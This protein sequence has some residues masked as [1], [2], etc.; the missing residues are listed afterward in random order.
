MIHQLKN[1]ITFV[2]PKSA[3]VP[4]SLCC[5]LEIKIHV[6]RQGQVWDLWEHLNVSVLLRISILDILTVGLFFLYQHGYLCLFSLLLK[7]CSVFIPW[8][9]FWPKQNCLF[10]CILLEVCRTVPMTGM[11]STARMH[12]KS[13]KRKGG[14]MGRFLR[15]H[16]LLR[17]PTRLFLIDVYF[18]FS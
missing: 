2:R 7:K 9:G 5:H 6:T 18:T 8:A 4:I 12:H 15:D 16:L 17:P 1:K 11:I 13:L 3:T 10:I 14:E